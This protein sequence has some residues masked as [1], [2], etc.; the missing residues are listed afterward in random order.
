MVVL[1]ATMLMALFRSDAGGPTN[2][3]GKPIN[4]A[5]ERIE[6]LVKQLEAAKTKII[7]PTPALSE[8]LVRAGAEES[9]QI[10]EEVNRSA[11]FRIEPFDTRAAIE[12]AAMTRAAISDGG[13]KGASRAPWAKVK[14]DRQIVAIAKVAQATAIY[15]DDNDVRSIAKSVRTLRTI[16]ATVFTAGVA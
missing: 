13:K 8:I 5:K 15:S 9:Q 1:D 3:K 6:N 4:D 12:V 14:Y 10:I 7:V 11:V 2:S 16:T